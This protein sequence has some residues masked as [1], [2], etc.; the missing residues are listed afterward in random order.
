MTDSD[1][2]P[3]A[4]APAGGLKALTGVLGFPQDGR[5]PLC[6]GWEHLAR[7]LLLRPDLGI[8]TREDVCCPRKKPFGIF[9][10]VQTFLN[11]IPHPI[12]HPHLAQDPPHARPIHVS[13]PW[14]ATAAV[15]QPQWTQ[16]QDGDH[17]NYPGVPPHPQ[18]WEVRGGA[19]RSQLWYRET[20]RAGK[21]LGDTSRLQKGVQ[22]T[23]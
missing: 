14:A 20:G 10:T 18:T 4:Q 11:P 21:E 12:P 3:K 19:S 9:P 8:R 15:G 13:F 23:S 22:S 5:P 6:S 1:P 7:S 2:P 17:R 16:L